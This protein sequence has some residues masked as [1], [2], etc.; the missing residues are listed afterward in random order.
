MQLSAAEDEIALAL[1]E[2]MPL[3]PRLGAAAAWILC[4]LA[5]THDAHDDSNSPDPNQD[6]ER[7]HDPSNASPNEQDSKGY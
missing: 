5:P 2:P 6:R 3:R 1:L 4:F 7:S